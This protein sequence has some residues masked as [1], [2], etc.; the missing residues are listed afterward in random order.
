MLEATGTKNLSPAIAAIQEQFEQWRCGRTKR[1]PIPHH[2]W[3]AAADLCKTYP[4]THVCR[5]LRL[6]YRE[7]KRRIGAPA[8]APVEFMEF[9][10]N[11][12]STGWHLECE[13]SDGTKLR[14]SAG[15]QP[16]AIGEVLR[17]F[18]S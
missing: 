16:P 12:L 13:R 5:Y 2:L 8:K 14:L 6:S 17:Q 4:I 1:E 15:G 3:E 18:L 7:L 11:C 9:D 10:L